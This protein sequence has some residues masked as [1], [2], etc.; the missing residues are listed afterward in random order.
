MSVK[1]KMTL[2]SKKTDVTAITADEKG[3]YIESETGDK[4]FI[5]SLDPKSGE[6]K[7]SIA[8]NHTGSIW[9]DADNVY[10]STKKGTIGAIS[11]LNHTV[12]WTY[13][14]KASEERYGSGI[15]C[16][17]P[18]D[19][20]IVVNINYSTSLIDRRTGK[21]LV[22]DP[23]SYIFHDAF[24]IVGNIVAIPTNNGVVARDIDTGKQLWK[25]E[26]ISYSDG[27]A[28]FNGKFVMQ[29]NGKLYWIEPKTGEITKT[30]QTGEDG[31]SGG[32]SY[33]TTV[34]GQLFYSGLKTAGIISSA[35]KT[36]WSGDESF[37]LRS[38]IWFVDGKAGVSG[39][40]G[41]LSIY[42]SGEIAPL[43]T[44]PVSRKAVFERMM[45][46]I[47]S[48][49]AIEQD[50]LALMVGENY[51]AVL[52]QIINWKKEDDSD[53]SDI[54]KL[55]ANATTSK[56]VNTLLKTYQTLKPDSDA[57]ILVASLLGRHA[58]PDIVVPLFIKDLEKAKTPGFELYQSLTYV[59]RRY[60]LSSEHPL[61]IKFLLKQL[62]DPKADEVLRNEAYTSVGKNG[63]PEA[64]QT[65]LAMRKK[66]QLLPPIS[67]RMELEKA[68]KADE[69][70]REMTSVLSTMKD[71]SGK[72]WGLLR[73]RVLANEGD[74]FIAERID[75]KWHNPKFTGV[76]TGTVSGFIKP[77]PSTKT[78][79]GFTADKLV[80]GE[81]KKIVGLSELSQ[82]T[83]HDGLTDLVE[84]RLGTNPKAEDTDGD[85]DKDDVD[86]MPNAARKPE[87]EAE[88]VINAAIEARY[89]NW[90]RDL[91]AL[92]DME[93]VKP[94]EVVGW[95]G[96]MLWS[97]DGEKWES[98]LSA[99]YERGVAL[100]SVYGNEKEPV[101]FNAAKDEASLS[102]STYFGG[103]SGDTYG[104]RLKKFGNEWIVIAM[105]MTSIS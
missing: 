33:V 22:S 3:L 77:R 67:E 21:E 30:I 43:P 94:F 39:Y 74:L 59:T 66:R 84:K 60:I 80:E 27:G 1:W 53:S 50:H 98:E 13:T 45:K 38:I 10:T 16:I 52:N 63:D 25:K 62:K 23:K 9:I 69:R 55:L 15:E 36:V 61:A 14:A 20:N 89:H 58:N 4:S 79:G 85:G 93:G 32:G 18:G 102:I 81:W 17:Q 19:K 70:S 88:K 72:E 34:G 26:K 103:L 65:I 47:K 24:I 82:D 29:D 78:I 68:V 64:I 31:W 54:Q 101:V 75:G 37:A 44:D 92:I 99:C 104:V 73:S 90:E 2:P 96:P 57:K 8:N 7:W 6:Q 83:D 97:T 40:G 42:D 87:T 105:G 95:S 71:A 76:F 56:H 48:L 11:R 51:E 5:H 86:P 41:K 35:G 49:D 12:K 46:S 100:I 28:V 91:P